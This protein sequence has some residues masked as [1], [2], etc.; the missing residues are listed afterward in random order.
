[1]YT[2]KVT[3]SSCCVV[4]KTSGNQLEAHMAEPEDGEIK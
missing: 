2:L 4:H 1:M 3:S